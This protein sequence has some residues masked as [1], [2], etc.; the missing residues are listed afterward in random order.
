MERDTCKTSVTGRPRIAWL[1]VCPPP[2]CSEREQMDVSVVVGAVT[3]QAWISLQRTYGEHVDASASAACISPPFLIPFPPPTCAIDAVLSA[4]LNAL[5]APL[6]AALS[7]PYTSP[8]SSPLP[9]GATLQSAT[10]VC[11]CV[12]VIVVVSLFRLARTQ[13]SVPRVWRVYVFSTVSQTVA[14]TAAAFFVCVLLFSLLPPLL[15]GVVLRASERVLVDQRACVR[16]PCIPSLSLSLSL[17]PPLC[18]PPHYRL[19]PTSRT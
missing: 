14:A 7:R 19:S 4:P 18:I 17:L 6:P 2:P 3:H 5:V 11:V 9:L 8:S 12:C 10:T 15:P 16:C 13:S 1:S